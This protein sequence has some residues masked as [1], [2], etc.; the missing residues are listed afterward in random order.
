[1]K[2]VVEPLEGNK[3]KVRIELD[4]AEFTTALDE[5]WGTIA[6][7][8]SL[9]GFRK[10]KVPKQVVKSRVDASFARGE[11]IQTAVPRA[12]EDAI[13]EHEID[14]IDQP[15][16]ELDEGAEE[17]PVI[18]T[19]TVEVRPELTLEGYG[20]LE[21]TV[22]NP[23]PADDEVADQ[24]DKLRTQFG[25][26][27]DVERAVGQDDYVTINL[28]ASRD[29]E[30]IAGMTAENYLYQVGSGGVVPELDTNL[31][32]LEQGESS[33][34]EAADPTAAPS[35]ADEDDADDSQ[36]TIT[37]EVEVLG[38]Q[39]RE[40][41]ELTDEWVADA[42]EFETVA[43]L[44]DDIV[45]R[46]SGQARDRAQS[47]VRNELATALVEL[48][49]DEVPEALVQA[50][51]QEQLES[52]A[53]MLSQSGIELGQYLQMTGQQPD[54]FRAQLTEEGARQAKVDLALR[55][56]AADQ[57]LAP[58][59]EELDEEL[60]HLAVHAEVEL[61]TARTNL[62]DNGQMPAL[63]A[64]IAKR[65][66]MD[67]LIDTAS[68]TDASGAPVDPELLKI[69]PHD[70]GHDEHSEEDE[71]GDGANEGDAAD[72]GQPTGADVVEDDA[73]IDPEDEA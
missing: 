41:P 1:M 22:A 43:E 20:S 24:I 4:D 51:A 33:T 66:A 60:A 56:V 45:D 29:G 40:L 3:V 67:W 69:D 8:A 17:G 38:I 2:S 73:E 70:H 39:E 34:F 68:I 13:R 12:Y 72:T 6:K 37:L 15:D 31:V 7:E 26:L 11:A 28:V 62:A 35:E 16:I 63:R 9:P 46:M 36:A 61:E 48:V 49:T 71:P 53:R 42:T 30:E 18:F 52:M 10:G 5:A 32:G 58:S 50:A 25:G 59:D 57:N 47:Q 55:A 65:K 54:E 21:V 27:V 44:R 14:A 19:A 23:H 64:D